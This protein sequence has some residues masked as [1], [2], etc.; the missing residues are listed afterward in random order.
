MIAPDIV[1]IASFLPIM[2][3]NQPH[4]PAIVLPKGRDRD[5]RAIYTHYTFEQLNRESD[6]IARGLEK[7]G[8]GRGV[9][10]ALMVKPGLEFIALTF[11]MFKV[12]AV[13]VVVDPGMGIKRML[14][15]FQECT[16][17]AFIGIPLA[18][19]VRTLYPK[20]FLQFV[21]PELKYG[22]IVCNVATPDPQL[23]LQP[24][25]MMQEVPCSAM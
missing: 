18:H 15:C 14:S 25:N 11:A 9:R 8:I 6:C 22:Y 24:V 16:P 3:K 2:A 1:N 19:G 17:T 20:F 10:T 23:A 5:G 7:A 21:Y 4:K 12:G 13:P